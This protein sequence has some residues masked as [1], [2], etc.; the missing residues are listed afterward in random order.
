MRLRNDRCKDVTGDF[1]HVPMAL[2]LLLAFEDAS[3][4]SQRTSVCRL[5]TSPV[6]WESQA[7]VSRSAGDIKQ[8]DRKISAGNG[9]YSSIVNLGVGPARITP[10]RIAVKITASVDVDRP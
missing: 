4:A 8:D 5:N 2:L 9:R 3:H 1:N 7:R 10:V 6:I